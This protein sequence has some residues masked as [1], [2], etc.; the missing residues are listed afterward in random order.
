MELK[1]KATGN[2]TE[3]GREMVIVD[4]NGNLRYQHRRMFACHSGSKSYLTCRAVKAPRTQACFPYTWHRKWQKKGFVIDFLDA[5]PGAH[6]ISFKGET[7]ISAVPKYVFTQQKDSEDFQSEL[8]GKRLEGTFEIRKISS[9]A[10]SNRYGE[11]TDQHLKIWQDYS[12]KECTVSF[13]ASA[14]SEPGH[15]EFPLVV[16]DQE[17]GFDKKMKEEMTL[18]FV[19][20]N[21]KKHSRAYSKD[22]SRSPTE[23]TTATNTTGE[24]NALMFMDSRLIHGIVPTIFSSNTEVASSA[25]SM[26]TVSTS[27]TA[28]G[29]YQFDGAGQSERSKSEKSLRSLAKD[30]KYIRIEFS[31]ETGERILIHVVKYHADVELENPRGLSRPLID[32]TKKKCRARKTSSKNGE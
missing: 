4:E 20:A 1:R 17:L 9:A 10:V 27:R 16:F 24:S 11:A 7:A 30:M 29:L 32:Y 23:A 21:E 8:R 28:S 3:N 5:P 18:N 22:L 31:D 15:K 19:L 14:V 6:S 12:S 26:T 25:S 2:D 13:Y